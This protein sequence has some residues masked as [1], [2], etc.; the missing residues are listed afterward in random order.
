M[1]NIPNHEDFAKIEPINKGWSSDKNYYIETI[2]GEKLLL[3]IS[4]IAVY[5]KKKAEF[6][7]VKLVAEQSISMSQPLDFGV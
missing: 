1:F 2:K 3:R 7:A 5:D 4:D 6:E